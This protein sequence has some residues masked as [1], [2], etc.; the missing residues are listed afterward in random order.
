MYKNKFNII[1]QNKIILFHRNTPCAYNHQQ[2]SMATCFGILDRLQTKD[3]IGAHYEICDHILF[4][5]C[6]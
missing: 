2:P 1:T 3:K 5:G 4:K 6:A